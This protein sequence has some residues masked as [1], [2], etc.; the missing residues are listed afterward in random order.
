MLTTFND[1]LESINSSSLQI[2]KM[3]GKIIP[4]EADY[5][6]EFTLLIFMNV[7]LGRKKF[8]GANKLFLDNNNTT[9]INKESEK[10]KELFNLSKIAYPINYIDSKTIPT[11][12]FYGGNDQTVGIGQYA[13]IKDKFDNVRNP[14]IS[15]I[16]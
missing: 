6:N 10:Y 8:E 5:M 11:I 14:N 16:Y 9:L 12:C 15:F 3:K 13:Y 7:W 1:T 4:L 2:A